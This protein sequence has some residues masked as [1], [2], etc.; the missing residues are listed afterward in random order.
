LAADLTVRWN[1]LKQAEAL[2]LG[3]AGVIPA[4]QTGTAMLISTKVTGIE[5]HVVGMPLLQARHES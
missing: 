4:W 5:Y 1:T 2:L 3:E